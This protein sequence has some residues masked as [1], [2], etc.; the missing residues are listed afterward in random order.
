MVAAERRQGGAQ[1][2]LN[3]RIRSRGTP[4]SASP[5]AQRLTGAPIP[6]RMSS[7]VTIWSATPSRKVPDSASS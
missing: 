2:N 5:D 4:A 1:D 3:R 7:M 6:P